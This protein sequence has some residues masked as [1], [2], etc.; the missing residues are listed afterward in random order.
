MGIYRPIEQQQVGKPI[1][2]ESD[3]ALFGPMRETP[4]GGGA[5]D[6]GDVRGE[7]P[8]ALS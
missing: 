6:G 4:E 1:K 3:D 5:A 7:P 8:F 2:L